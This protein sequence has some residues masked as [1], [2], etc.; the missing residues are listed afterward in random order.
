MDYVSSYTSDAGTFE[1]IATN[2]DLPFK[3]TYSGF[4][5]DYLYGNGHL[6]KFLTPS[7]YPVHFNNYFD[8]SWLN[9]FDQNIRLR[10]ELYKNGSIIDVQY[11]SISDYGIGL[12]RKKIS[13]SGNEDRID[14]AI[15][16]NSTQSIDFSNATTW[17][18]GTI[19]WLSLSPATASLLILTSG[20]VKTVN[21][22]VPYTS[23][24]GVTYLINYSITLS[25]KSGNAFSMTFLVNAT[26]GKN[27][28]IYGTDSVLKN[29][30]GT[31]TGTLTFTPSSI[32]TY[33][34][35]EFDLFSTPSGGSWTGVVNSLTISANVSNVDLSETKTLTIDTSCTSN[36]IDLSWLNYLGGFDYWRFKGFADYGAD[37]ENTSQSDK[38]IIPNYPKSIGANADTLRFETKRESRNKVLCRAENLTADQVQDLYRIKLSPLVQIV[39]SETDRKTIILDSDSFFHYPQGNKL[40]EFS[41]TF[42]MTDA[43]PVQEQ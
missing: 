14:A 4:M 32:C 39:N 7:L 33:L 29:A 20:T 36:Y 34:S 30:D 21:L 35:I 31:Y 9:Q 38:N 5:S 18:T 13:L 3:N 37:I 28:P 2:S 10:R 24:P 27:L 8:I 40:F 23:F 41:F 22:A 43:N 11:D 17:G 15:V 42:S 6:L 12:Y 19:N 16:Y 26:N 25:A 1:G